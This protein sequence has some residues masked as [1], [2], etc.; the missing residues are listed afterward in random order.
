MKEVSC[1]PAPL[2]PARRPGQPALQRRQ[3]VAPARVDLDVGPRPLSAFPP[4][5]ESAT[6]QRADRSERADRSGTA[7]QM[8]EPMRGAG[9]S[10]AA[11]PAPDAKASN[12]AMCGFVSAELARLGD[13]ADVAASDD[14]R[15]RIATQ[16][17]RLK[18]RQARLKC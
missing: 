18:A 3:V 2:G 11:M 13:E 6:G 5:P 12:Q 14:V 4:L 16:Q 1:A 9:R 15:A 7:E 10:V 8:D 17:Q